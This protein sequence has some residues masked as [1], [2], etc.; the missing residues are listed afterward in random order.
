M[1]VVCGRIFWREAFRHKIRDRIS[2]PVVDQHVLPVLLVYAALEGSVARFGLL[3][4]LLLFGGALRAERRARGKGKKQQEKRASAA[5]HG[6]VPDVIF[7]NWRAKPYLT[8]RSLKRQ[9]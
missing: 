8:R 7:S 2:G 9:R 4:L 6:L 3:R 5:M 1:L